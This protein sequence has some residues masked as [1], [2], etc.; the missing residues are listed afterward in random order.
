MVD[1]QILKSKLHILLNFEFFLLSQTS[2]YLVQLISLV[3]LKHVVSFL[4]VFLPSLLFLLPFLIQTLSVIV[5]LA[6]SIT[7]TTLA[8]CYPFSESEKQRPRSGQLVTW[9]KT[10]PVPS[11]PGLPALTPVSLAQTFAPACPASPWHHRELVSACPQVMSPK[12]A[13]TIFPSSLNGD[14]VRPPPHPRHHSLLW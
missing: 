11:C 8:R 12:P 13:S 9:D 10:S 7:V 5:W 1:S 4:L 3:A 14:P 6:L 2:I